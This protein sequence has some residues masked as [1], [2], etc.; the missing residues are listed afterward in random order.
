MGFE[1]APRQTTADFLTSLTS[2]TERIVKPG[3]EDKTPRTAAEFVVAWKRTPEY[4]ALIRDIEAYEDKYPIGGPSVAEFTAWRR[5]QQAPQQ[6]VF[7]YH[8]IS[9]LTV[10]YQL[11]VIQE[12]S[13]PVYPFPLSTGHVMR[14]SRLPEIKRGCQ[15]HYFACRWKYYLGIGCWYEGDHENPMHASC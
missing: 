1:S 4:A 2:P 15:C 8:Y 10:K 3:Y 7:Y 5:A 9:T 12:G 13:I 6:Y 11:I 14:R